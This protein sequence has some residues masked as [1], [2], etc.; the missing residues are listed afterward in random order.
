MPYSIIIPIYNE[1]RTLEKLLKSLEQYSYSRNQILIINDGSID[2][3]NK[4]LKKYDFIDVLHLKK[5]YGKGTAIK[6]GLHK[7]IHNKT[8]IYDGDL[9]LHTDGISELMRLD[10]DNGV[11]SVLGQRFKKLSFLNSKFDWGNFVFTS[12]FNFVSFTHNEDVLCCAKSFFKK[13]IPL[14]KLKSKGF[15]IDIELSWILVKNNKLKRIKHI[16][17]NYQRRS[18]KE[19]KKLKINDGWKILRR[20]ISMI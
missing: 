1:E 3:T 5:N 16:F 17:L 20:V 11:N 14:D 9:E 15:D 4:I 13:D 2:K 6:I 8:I 18:V 12:F 19:G 10:R 7:S